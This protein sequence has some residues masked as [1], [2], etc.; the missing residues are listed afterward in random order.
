M[1][2]LTQSPPEGIKV[3]LNED[4]VTDIQAIIEGP[5]KLALLSL[6]KLIRPLPLLN[7]TP[8]RLLKTTLRGYGANA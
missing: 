7:S 8:T 4:D 6:A 2:E 1:L 5:G 3:F